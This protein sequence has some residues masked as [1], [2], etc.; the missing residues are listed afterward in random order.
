MPGFRAGS[1][2]WAMLLGEQVI[3]LSGET[4]ATIWNRGSFRPTNL[5]KLRR[6]I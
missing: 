2:T 3:L 4:R 5:G 1:I 6:R